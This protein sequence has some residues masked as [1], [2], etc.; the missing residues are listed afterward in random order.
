MG[1]ERYETSAN[2][3]TH[4]GFEVLLGGFDAVSGCMSLK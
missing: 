4:P 1:H 3:Y 2:T